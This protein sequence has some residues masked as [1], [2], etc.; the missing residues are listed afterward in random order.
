MIDLNPEIVANIASIAREFQTMAS[1]DTDTSPEMVN[2][3][4]DLD[5]LR[6]W[7]GDTS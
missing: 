6:E 7:H 5:Q 2:D 4:P 1:M 3:D